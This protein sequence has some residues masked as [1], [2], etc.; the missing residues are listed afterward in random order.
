MEA[1]KTYRLTCLSKATSLLTHNS[2]VQGNEQIVMREGVSTDD[3]LRFVP[4]LSGNALR[5]RI[6]REPGARYLVDAWELRGNLSLDQLNWLFHGGNLSQ[7]TAHVS[8]SRQQELF[9]LFPLIR[10]IGCSLPNQIVAGSL[11]CHRGTLVCRENS[12]RLKAATPEGWQADYAALR[13]AEHFIEQ[14]QYT[15]SDARH[16]ARDLAPT[17]GEDADSNLMIFG[18]Q[19]VIAGAAFL[20]GFLARHVG[21]LELGCLLLSLRLW[22]AHG[23][24]IGGQASRGHGRLATSLHIAPDVDQE[25]VIQKYTDHVAS[26][27]DEAVAFLDGNFAP[28]DENKK[29]RKKVKA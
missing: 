1:T 9:R 19:S 13:S 12:W 28:P 20:H 21:D 4:V 14:Y 24:T 10:L 7:S 18:G 15:R 22:Q 5:H 16:T 17:N 2:G 8:L 11:D 23:G 26:V 3:G 27:R 25:A 29:S 6:V